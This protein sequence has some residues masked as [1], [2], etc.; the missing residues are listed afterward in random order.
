MY[1]TIHRNRMCMF[2]HVCECLLA[3]L[4]VKI[5]GNLTNEML[6]IQITDVL[7]LDII[8]ASYYYYK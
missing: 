5:E 2:V 7:I 3:P 1:E 8:Q 6:E 4:G